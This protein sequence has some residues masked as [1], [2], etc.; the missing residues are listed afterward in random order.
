MSS[1]IPEGV[2]Q[3]YIHQLADNRQAQCL[4]CRH[5]QAGERTDG[6]ADRAD[7]TGARCYGAIKDRKRLRMGRSVQ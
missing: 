2:S 5:R 6:N 3:S 7:E 1:A 4:P